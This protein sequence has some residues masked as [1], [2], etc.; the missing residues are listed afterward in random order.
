MLA[1]RAS[2]PSADLLRPSA[3]VG[4]RPRQEE[5]TLCTAAEASLAKR[6][7]FRASW[8]GR[9]ARVESSLRS[10]STP[11]GLGGSLAEGSSSL[12]ML[13]CPPILLG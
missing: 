9:E 5:D 1:R 6:D 4:T 8:Q 12:P 13:A 2:A 3:F 7:P 11:L 10:F